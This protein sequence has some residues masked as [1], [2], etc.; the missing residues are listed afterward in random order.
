MR[1]LRDSGSVGNKPDTKVGEPAMERSGKGALHGNLRRQA[2]PATGESLEAL[3]ME[4]GSGGGGR[5]RGRAPCAAPAGP[6]GEDL[7][8]C[9]RAG[10]LDL[11]SVG[12]FLVL[13][14]VPLIAR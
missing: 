8:A 4:M 2:H 11:R 10:E 6:A 13:L 3:F 1:V 7:R 14:S 5:G 12:R 9:R